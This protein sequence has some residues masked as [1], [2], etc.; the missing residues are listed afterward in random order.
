MSERNPRGTT[1]P[2]DLPW[3]DV[4]ADSDVVPGTE[5]P[6][7]AEVE[8]DEGDEVDVSHPPIPDPSLKYQRETLD[9]RLAEEVPDRATVE[10]DREAGELQAAESDQ[11]DLSLDLGE[12][13]DEP[14]AD[15]DDEDEAAEDA[16][17][18]IRDADHT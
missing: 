18:H 7:P 6:D 10:D 2:R 13:D 3:N 14:Y 15:D 8:G 17:I 11:D 9:Q 1:P 12:S 16:A 5:E 4:P